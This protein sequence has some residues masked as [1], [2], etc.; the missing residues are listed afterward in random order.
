MTKKYSG[1]CTQKM[2]FNRWWDKNTKKVSRYARIYEIPTFSTAFDLPPPS[3]GRRVVLIVETT[4]LIIVTETCD[5]FD[6]EALEKNFEAFY[7]FE[8]IH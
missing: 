4:S 6:G 3:V 5:K 8:D 1:G 2:S 7:F